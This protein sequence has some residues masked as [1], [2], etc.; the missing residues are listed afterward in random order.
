MGERDAGYARSKRSKNCGS[1]ET[2]LTMVFKLMEC[3]EKRWRKFKGFGKLEL[4]IN[5]VKFK[6][7]EMLKTEDDRVAA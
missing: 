5:N 6:D 4:V 1:R 2:T 3:A 7:G